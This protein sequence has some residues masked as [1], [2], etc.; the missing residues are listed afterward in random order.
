MTR[1][2]EPDPQRL[3]AAHAAANEFYRS[4]IL[5]EPRGL[6][7]LH[8][9][10]IVA[11]IAH[12]A[13]W[14]IGYAPRGWTHLRDHLRGA[15]FTDPEL[16]AAGLITTASNGNLID[17][18]RDRVTFPIRNPDGHV[19]AFTA[20]DLSGRPN[21][22]KYRNTTTTAIYQKKTILFGLAEQ[23]GGDIQPRAV[24]L[25][26]GPADVVAVARLTSP[27]SEDPRRPYAAVAPCGTALTAEHLALLAAAVPP[28]T[29]LISAFD[30]DPAGQGAI[31][32]SYPL[33][34][35]WPGPVEA[36]A[37][38][39]GTDPA[40]LVAAGRTQAAQMMEQARRPL[41]DLVLDHLLAPHQ[42]RL[43]TR[44]AELA[45]FGRDP[46][47]ESVSMRLDAVRSVAP[48]IIEVAATDPAEAARLAAHL[49]TRLDLEPLAVFEAIYPP[50][51]STALDPTEQHNGSVPADASAPDRPPAIPLGAAGFP[52]PDLVGHEYARACPPAAAAAT[53]VE[54]D[55]ATGHS[56]WVIAEGVTDAPGDRA[57]AV[58]AAEVAGRAAI[59]VGAHKAVDV[60]RTALNAH[61]AQT[62]AG[63]GDATIAVLTSFD[64]DRPAPGVGRFTVA[65]AGDTRVYGAT[66]RWFAPLTVDHTLRERTMRHDRHAP[67]VPG[68]GALTA[69]VR[70]GPIGVNRVDL[71]VTQLVI[72]GR[73]LSRTA[74]D[75]VREAVE[76][77][78]PADAVERLIRLAGAP[79]AAL[80][81]RPRPGH[82]GRAINAARLAQQDQAAGASTA[83]PALAS[84]RLA[85]RALPAAPTPPQPVR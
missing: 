20:R 56:A 64:G 19:V 22:P 25:V 60:A 69:S 12:T 42:A 26:E 58:L 23:L 49:T 47:S 70:G 52:H 76:W 13:P 55:V 33:L 53:W 66:A 68:D 1:P 62:G 78:R 15:G 50:D 32:K 61:F 45:R 75:T 77:R 67:A 84:S 34:R 4:H 31:D 80:V 85:R 16:L 37:L 3:I 81:V 40:G 6:R 7:Y 24:M 46:S 5:D 14:T 30:G 51:E 59:L 39:A 57:A 48:L 82:A 18:F 74:L 17:V 2:R 71:P 29:P 65:W 43:E 11:A 8:S 36:I 63:R 44:L 28:G 41:V 35:S 9:R 38:P 83:M 72:A 79:T 54:H 21:T 10:G 27:D 73:A